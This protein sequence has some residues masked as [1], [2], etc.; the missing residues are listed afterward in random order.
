MFNFF[1]TD[2]PCASA[3]GISPGA[4]F[5][6]L[7]A[8][9]ATNAASL[10]VLSKTLGRKTV[11]VYLAVTAV[12]AVG[13]GLLLDAII[14]WLSLPMPE[15]SLQAVVQS[16]STLKIISGVVF[17]GLILRS[18]INKLVVRIKTGKNKCRKEEN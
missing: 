1:Y 13:F 15:F 2:S 8:G 11:A 14:G 7:F 10:A 6:F 17:G 16:T 18:L 5:V 12:S 4:A 9:P 3:K